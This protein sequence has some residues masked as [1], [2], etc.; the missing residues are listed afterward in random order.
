[1]VP[2]FPLQQRPFPNICKPLSYSCVLEIL[3]HFLSTAY[4]SQ[5]F[6][7]QPV[8]AAGWEKMEGLYL[9][10]GDVV[11]G[12]WAAVIC[13]VVFSLFLFFNLLC[14]GHPIK[15]S[16]MLHHI[17]NLLPIALN[18]SIY[19][20][21][22]PLATIIEDLINQISPTFLPAFC[23]IARSSFLTSLQMSQ[24]HLLRF[25]TCKRLCK[26]Q[27]SANLGRGL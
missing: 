14:F 4:K 11:R 6:L 24:C 19:E 5:P 25:D 3:S 26:L 16:D 27:R 21:H 12:T 20:R 23:N 15:N 13:L 22:T 2:T 18:R 9:E 7:F 8:P 1:M 10:G 17:V